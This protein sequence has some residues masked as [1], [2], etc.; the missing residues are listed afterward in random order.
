MNTKRQNGM[1]VFVA[2]AGKEN[3]NS[4]EPQ[5][6]GTDAKLYTILVLIVGI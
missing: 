1:A 2:V 3:I 6:L 4:M 5:N